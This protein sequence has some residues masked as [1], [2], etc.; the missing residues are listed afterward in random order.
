MDDQKMADVLMHTS[1]PEEFLCSGSLIGDKYRVINRI[2]TFGNSELWKGQYIKGDRAVAVKVICTAA[3]TEANRMWAI[4]NVL[5]SNLEAKVHHFVVATDVISSPERDCLVFEWHGVTVKTVIQHPGIMPL[6]ASHVRA[7]VWQVLKGIQH[8]HSLGIAHTDINPENVVFV[9]DSLATMRI[10]GSGG[11]FYER[12]MLCSPQVKIIG[13][14]HSR[15]V[16]STQNDLAGTDCYRAPEIYCGIGWALPVDI[17]AIGCFLFE[18]YTGGRLFPTCDTPSK[19]FACREKAIGRFNLEFVLRT[20]MQCKGMFRMDR[21]PLVAWIPEICQDDPQFMNYMRAKYS[22]LIRVKIPDMIDFLDRALQLDAIRRPA[23]HD[24]LRHRFFRELATGNSTMP[25]SYKFRA[26]DEDEGPAQ[27]ANDVLL[28]AIYSDLLSGDKEQCARVLV[29]NLPI[30]DAPNRGISNISRGVTNAN[31]DYGR[32]RPFHPFTGSFISGNE[33]SLLFGVQLDELI[34][35]IRQQLR[36]A[37]R[38]Q[39]EH[40]TVAALPNHEHYVLH[41]SGAINEGAQFDV[42][43]SVGEG[44]V[45]STVFNESLGNTVLQHGYEADGDP[46]TANGASGQGV[47]P[48]NELPFQTLDTFLEQAK[49]LDTLGLTLDLSSVEDMLAVFSDSGSLPLLH[50]PLPSGVQDTAAFLANGLSSDSWSGDS[51][52]SV[53]SLAGN[54][55]LVPA[56]DVTAFVPSLE[57]LPDVGYPATA[58]QEIDPDLVLGLHG[59]CTAQDIE[60]LDI[61]ST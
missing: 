60:N 49:T 58:L 61:H 50:D 52:S 55:S 10:L 1:L 57:N 2:A 41:N 16:N 36:V 18:L 4:S 17:F 6:P 39:V 43:G 5:R 45:N 21:L 40:P 56:G 12:R 15:L 11:H 59:I 26:L 32:G 7:I 14:E 23:A 47:L 29:E 22:P 54:I 53:P 20:Q 3:K 9:D 8:L 42:E 38:P 34:D 51:T 27:L 25:P 33:D 48:S 35:R 30:V 44:L 19:A 28:L 13:L 46:S 24:L 31:R 37:S